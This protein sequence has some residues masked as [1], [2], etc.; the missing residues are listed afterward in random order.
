VTPRRWADPPARGPAR[1]APADET[2]VSQQ[3]VSRAAHCGRI[4]SA[5]ADRGRVPRTATGRMAPDQP[6]RRPPRSP[7]LR[8][9]RT[10]RTAAAGLRHHRQGPL[11]SSLRPLRPDPR[12][13]P[14]PLDRRLDHR[15]LDSAAARAP[16]F[17][18][19]HLA[20]GARAWSPSAASTTP[21]KSRSPARSTPCS[22]APTRARP[23]N[24][25]RSPAPARHLRRSAGPR[26]RR[27]RTSQPRIPG[28]P[29]W[30]R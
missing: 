14:Q 2:L 29:S 23:D 20:R 22:P 19:V 28:R 21:T 4:C 5:A 18:R 10:R 27:P 12:L 6:R 15:T 13:D 24:V 30:R 3:H 1:P 11:G 16:A 9:H 7:H 17:R 25:A 26:L 8:L